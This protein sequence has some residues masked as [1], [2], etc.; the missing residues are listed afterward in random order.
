MLI[1]SSSFFLSTLNSSVLSYYS[2]G[3]NGYK[4]YF[5]WAFSPWGMPE[6]ISRNGFVCFYNMNTN[7]VL[8]SVVAFSYSWEMNLSPSMWI[9][10]TVIFLKIFV[11]SNNVV[12][13][14]MNFQESCFFFLLQ[15]LVTPWIHYFFFY[16]FKIHFIVLVRPNKNWKDFKKKNLLVLFQAMTW[17]CW[18]KKIV[19]FSEW[20]F[21]MLMRLSSMYKMWSNI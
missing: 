15:F 1:F 6:A 12:A 17:N 13:L 18:K 4:S 21:A 19:P 10:S 7:Y 16:I 20:S 5:F 2:W 11:P 14:Y 8:S 9:C 3:R